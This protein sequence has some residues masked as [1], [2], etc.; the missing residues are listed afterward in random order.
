MGFLIDQQKKKAMPLSTA[1]NW[2]LLGGIV[3]NTNIWEELSDSFNVAIT[4]LCSKYLF[5]NA[6]MQQK[7]SLLQT[8]T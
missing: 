2:K 7:N 3:F 4:L 6:A 8:M 5:C 1:S